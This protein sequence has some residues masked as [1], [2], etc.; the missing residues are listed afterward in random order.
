MLKIG[1]L[2]PT[3]DAIASGR[4]EATPLLEMARQA[5]AVGFDSVWV[6]DSLLARPRLEPLTLLA[7]IAAHTQRVTLGTAVLLPAL[8]HPLLLAHIVATLDRI[9]QGRLILGVGVGFKY[10]PTQKEFEAV[11]APF[12][13]R[14]SRLAEIIR[15]CRLLWST[16]GPV[17]MQ[18]KHWTLEDVELL[19]KPHQPEGP[20]IWMAGDGP[21]AL[22]HAG[23]IS[24]GWLPYSPTVEKFSSGWARVQETAR[25]AG[26]TV[27]PALY[28]TV[29]LN[30][31]EDEMR[32]Y[33]Q[34]YYNVPFEGI[35]A[36]QAC[37]AGSAQGC[38][39]WLQ[40]YVKAGAQHLVLRLGSF[41]FAS[42]L[43][44][45]ARDLL[46]KLRAL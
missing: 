23:Q 25:E 13:R 43:E 46:P 8:R 6:G 5:E 12:E 1:V 7:A 33:I 3:R 17:T 36:F 35:A 24:D 22:R 31:N 19:P 42:Q 14:V 27:A 9:A 45:V 29:N 38:A 26:R 37:Y 16:D 21:S 32:D 10:P 2:L 44:R 39:E 30:E 40:G 4:P 15:T 41:D 18:G 28:A 11:G 20:P 34:R